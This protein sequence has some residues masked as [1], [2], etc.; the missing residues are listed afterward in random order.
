VI[1]VELEFEK[2]N[3]SLGFL[4]VLRAK[5]RETW[6]GSEKLRVD[7]RS[8]CFLDLSANAA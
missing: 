6:K 4:N 3:Q 1:V 5:T 8:M 7:S 2:R